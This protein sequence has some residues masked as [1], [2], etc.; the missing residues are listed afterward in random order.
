MEHTT[1]GRALAI[2]A[3]ITFTAG[4]LVVLM[5]DVL[6]TPALWDRFHVLTILTVAA[7]IFAG[8]M[9]AEAKGARTYLAAVGFV[10]AFAVGTA[11]VVANSIGKQAEVSGTRALDAEATNTAIAAKSADLA[12]AKLRFDDANKWAD[13][14]MSGERC[15]QRCKDWRLRATEVGAHIKAIEAE[16]AALGPQKVANAKSERVG[17]IAA[18]FGYD[19][20]K[21]KVGFELL[22]P[23]LWSAFFELGA[24]VSFWFAFRPVRKAPV[25]DNAQTSFHFEPLPPAKQLPPLDKTLPA[26]KGENVVDWSKRYFAKHGEWPKLN[27]IE[28]AF[29]EQIEAGEFSR[30]TAY[31]RVKA[32]KAA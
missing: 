4:S 10:L 15:G 32:L 3:G 8:H 31:R 24:I 5:G 6:T 9:I 25:N 17:E 27:Q 7:T 11:L 26:L 2:I 23:L 20:T 19:K 16:I 18:L 22:E 13:K 1:N 12:K 29:A 21:A 30:S 14:E 28:A